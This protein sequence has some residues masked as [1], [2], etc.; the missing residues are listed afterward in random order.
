MGTGDEKE[1]LDVA[2]VIERLNA[3]LPLQLRSA[4]AYTIAAGSVTGFAY[5]PLGP[6][7]WTFA[8]AE[9]EDARRLV[10]K[11][12]A[13]GGVPSTEVAEVVHHPEAPETIAWLIEVETEVV[14]RLQDVI[15]ATGQTGPSE[16]LEHRLEHLIMR[17]QEQIDTLERARRG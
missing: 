8:A 11:V 5:T 7:L 4:V 14:E 6:Q 13:L 3:A 2:T 12:V 1:P 15:P 17:K 10:E 16:A 9:L